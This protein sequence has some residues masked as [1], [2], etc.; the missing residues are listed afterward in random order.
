MDVLELQATLG[1][2]MDSLGS[3]DMVHVHCTRG[4]ELFITFARTI[5]V[6][7]NEG[8]SQLPPD[9]GTFPLHSV[10]DCQGKLPQTMADKGGIFF[11]MYRKLFTSDLPQRYD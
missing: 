4:D 5:R 9:L 10:A 6:P 7:D 2:S 8:H 1:E 3:N 11:P